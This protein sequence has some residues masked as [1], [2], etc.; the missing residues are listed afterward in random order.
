M[1]VVASTPLLANTGNRLGDIVAEGL[2][3]HRSHLVHVLAHV[4]LVARGD[5]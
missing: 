2:A 1:V 5:L 4:A 3:P